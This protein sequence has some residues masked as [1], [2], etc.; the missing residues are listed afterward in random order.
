MFRNA[1][2]N[3]SPTEIYCAIINHHL[4]WFENVVANALWRAQTVCIRFL[5][6]PRPTV[7]LEDI[8]TA[9]PS[10][11][12]FGRLHSHSCLKFFAFLLFLAD[13]MFFCEISVCTTSFFISHSFRW[14]VFV[15]LHTISHPDIRSSKKPIANRFVQLWVRM[16]IRNWMRY[17]S[18]YQHSKVHRC[19]ITSSGTLP[20][21]D[22]GF[23][24]THINLVDPLPPFNGF[25]ILFTCVDR[26]TH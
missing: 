1:W 20:L 15:H 11:P 3:Y 7:N 22:G 4:T 6:P 23:R 16:E 12:E 21:P 24:H 10:N 26:L 13:E 9:Q 19:T 2:D 5:P 17:C 8:A 18:P 25:T 14:A